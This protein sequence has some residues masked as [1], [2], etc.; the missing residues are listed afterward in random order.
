MS[1]SRKKKILVHT[2]CV[3]CASYVFS[4]LEKMYTV[5]A[6]FYN[7]EIHGRAEYKKRLN[8]LEI[9][10]QDNNIQMIV[11][12]YNIQDFLS[13]L[14]PYHDNRSIKYISDKDRYKRKRCQL[15]S[16]LLINN[17]VALAKKMRIKNFTTTMLCS[18]YRDHN[19]IWDKSLELS[20]IYKLNFHYQDYRK[21]YWR[22]RNYARS[23]GYSI[24]TYCGCSESLDEG[25]LE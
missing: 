4:E 15:C 20:T 9:Y 25:R 17:T 8:D 19:E 3:S 21:G 7:P 23:R 6:Y 2:C 12:P 13:M 22:G 18:P 16:S 1:K 14:A 5:V 11:P 24:P 10:C